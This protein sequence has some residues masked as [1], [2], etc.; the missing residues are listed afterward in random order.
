MVDIKKYGPEGTAFHHHTSKLRPGMF[1]D[2][3]CHNS[4]E[5]I[6]VISGNI[7]HV[8][9]GRKYQLCSGDLALVRPSTYH[10]LQ[11][12]S[13]EP[14][15]R[16]NILFDP[17]QHGIFAATQLPKE[18]EAV[19]LSENRM[20]QDLFHK[21]DLY[22]Q[23][24]DADFEML[25]KLLLNELCMN[26]LLFHREKPQKETVISPILTQ[27]LE[28]I[29]NNLFSIQDVAQIAQALFISPSYL[30]RLFRT[31]MHQSPKKYIQDKR[32]LAAQRRLRA[33]DKPTTVCRECGF[34]E[35]AT[36]YRNYVAYFGHSPS[37][38]F[39]EG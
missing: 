3:H 7:A 29:N 10:Y 14:Y 34:R 13:E 32:L 19:K 8:V 11:I 5:L 30:Y 38:E 23:A 1:A 21:M 37:S 16:Y 18:L 27:T 28:Y 25:L 36:F 9:E 33:G 22:A 31:S 6:Y 4:F 17:Q 24:D 12:L 26:L 35:Y 2:L 20:L 15:E 39:S